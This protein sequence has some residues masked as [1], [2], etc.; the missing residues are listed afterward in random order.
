[1]TDKQIEQLAI[2][3]SQLVLDGLSELEYQEEIPQV[4]QEEELLAELATL[5]T[6]LD[7]N[8]KLEAYTKCEEIKRKIIKVENKLN[9]YK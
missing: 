2:R 4:S 7:F 6:Q 8:L 1:M 9:N 3:V 5:M